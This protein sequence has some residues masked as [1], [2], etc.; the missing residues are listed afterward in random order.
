MSAW[1]D[2]AIEEARGYLAAL[3]FIRDLGAHENP[4][5]LDDADRTLRQ[6]D[7]SEPWHRGV[8]DAFNLVRETR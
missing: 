1:I 8:R 5:A 4:Q 3:E 7:Q 2:T 6:K